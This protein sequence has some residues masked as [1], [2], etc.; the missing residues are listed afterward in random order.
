M[1]SLDFVPVYD[2]Y[3]ALVSVRAIIHRQAEVMVGGRIV[4]PRQRLRHHVILPD[5]ALGTVARYA[6]VF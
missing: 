6:R 3:Y 5:L 1:F 2:T 4:H